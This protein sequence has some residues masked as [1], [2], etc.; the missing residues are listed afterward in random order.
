MKTTLFI[1]GISLLIV[2]IAKLLTRGYE[3]NITLKNHTNNALYVSE[4]SS[5]ERASDG[6]L[7]VDTSQTK[8]SQGSSKAFMNKTAKPGIEAMVQLNM[9]D[10]EGKKIGAVSG[11]HKGGTK[12]GVKYQCDP[13]DLSISHKLIDGNEIK[14]FYEV[15]VSNK[16]L[17][18]F[19]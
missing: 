14:A 4:N 10:A 5:P 18:Q 1:V 11:H 7:R 12:Y 9:F 6:V 15:T 17:K 16:P 8:L 19:L 13:E 2:W 3:L